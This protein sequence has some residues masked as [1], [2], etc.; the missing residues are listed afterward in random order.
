MFG[1]LPEFLGDEPLS[2]DEATTME[3]S[4][5]NPHFASCY[6][7]ANSSMAT[8]VPTPTGAFTV[9]TLLSVKVPSP[10]KNTSPYSSPSASSLASSIKR[11]SFIFNSNSSFVNP[12]AQDNNNNNTINS[13]NSN[14]NSN[15][16]NAAAAITN[17]NH[18]NNIYS[19]AAAGSSVVSN[20][21][22]PRSDKSPQF[23]VGIAS[24]RLKEEEDDTMKANLKKKSQN[25]PSIATTTTTATTSSKNSNSNGPIAAASAAPADEVAALEAD[26]TTTPSPPTIPLIPTSVTLATTT[27]S[28]SHA[29]PHTLPNPRTP[30]DN[31]DPR[32]QNSTDDLDKSVRSCVNVSRS[33]NSDKPYLDS[34]TRSNHHLQPSTSSPSKSVSPSQPSGTTSTEMSSSTLSLVVPT[35]GSSTN[36]L[37]TGRQTITNDV[38]TPIPTLAVNVKSSSGSSSTITSST[39]KETSPER[40]S[41][42]KLEPTTSNITGSNRDINSA[43]SSPISGN[44]LSSGFHE[45]R[46]SS[47][48]PSF[49]YPFSDS[50]SS[51]DSSMIFERSVQEIHATDNNNKIPLHHSNDDFIPPVLDA[52]TEALTNRSLDPESIEIL[53]LRRPSS[54][55]SFSFSDNPHGFPSVGSASLAFNVAN[56][57]QAFNDPINSSL[58]SFSRKESFASAHSFLPPPGMV[59]H[60]TSPNNS[61]NL[62]LPPSSTYMK[63]PSG[64]ALP[65]LTAYNSNMSLNKNTQRS[66]TSTFNNKKDG[67]VLSFCSFADLVNAEHINAINPSSTI[68]STI[69]SPT[70]A[71]SQDTVPVPMATS[72]GSPTQ[73]MLK[74]FPSRSQDSS[75]SLNNS[76]SFS[77]FPENSRRLQKSS[78]KLSLAQSDGGDFDINGLDICSLGETLRRNTN[79]ISSHS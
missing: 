4:L 22:L 52:S 42:H 50:C 75:A 33:S 28:C 59:D 60:S 16:T 71:S 43:L 17:N 48:S 11:H 79:V 20:R 32:L 21:Q 65:S 31:P 39:K 63:S 24:F 7:Q 14:N 45:T 41:S 47:I 40:G 57:N 1:L 64:T 8:P 69:N 72:P 77:Q 56:S 15:S 12:S 6:P 62:P 44:L 10:P 2:A 25:L 73:L 18:N 54:V 38:T 29:T 78:S 55:R 66:A 36:G 13:S 26:N 61:L 19:A 35:Q 30:F 68:N 23:T 49:T 74:S 53:S 27:K 70:T 46:H 76:Y 5:S 37:L 3:Q 9:E 67:R 34:V 58:G 51:P